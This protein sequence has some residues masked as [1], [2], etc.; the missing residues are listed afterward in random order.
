MVVIRCPRC[1]SFKQPKEHQTLADSYL[2][3]SQ[4]WMHGVDVGEDTFIDCSEERRGLMCTAQSASIPTLLLTLC[5]V[6]VIEYSCEIVFVHCLLSNQQRHIC[7]DKNGAAWQHLLSFS[8]HTYGNRKSLKTLSALHFTSTHSL[9]PKN[10][11]WSNFVAIRLVAL[12][13]YGSCLKAPLMHANNSS[14]RSSAPWYPYLT[15][16][17]H[18]AINFEPNSDYFVDISQWKSGVCLQT[19]GLQWILGLFAKLLDV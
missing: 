14:F 16:I 3:T 15:L 9:E 12:A 17:W 18:Q 7:G 19:T 11:E 13:K 6:Y 8:H 1:A 5:N 10:D 2:D 4:W